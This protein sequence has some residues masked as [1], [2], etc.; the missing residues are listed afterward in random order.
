ML[1]EAKHHGTHVTSWKWASGLTDTS[2]WLRRRTHPRKKVSNRP[3]R[4]ELCDKN[5]VHGVGLIHVVYTFFIPPKHQ[6]SRA[7]AVKLGKKFCRRYN[8]LMTEHNVQRQI[9]RLLGQYEHARFTDIKP[10]ELENNAFQYQNIS[11]HAV[12]LVY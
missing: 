9:L 7:A 5:I 6:I 10:P 11:T 3:N 2:R 1:R 8:H 12:S 4:S